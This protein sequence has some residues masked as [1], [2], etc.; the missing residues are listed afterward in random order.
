LI[1]AGVIEATE[2]RA[3]IIA[4]PDTPYISLENADEVPADDFDVAEEGEESANRDTQRQGSA[5]G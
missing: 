5:R 3:R 2:A 4:D 1:E